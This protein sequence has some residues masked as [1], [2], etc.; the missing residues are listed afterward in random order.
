MK[1][2]LSLGVLIIFVCLF[3]VGC[4][5]SAQPTVLRVAIPYSDNVLDPETNYYINWLEKE[6]GFDIEPVIVRQ[7]VAVEYL[8]TLF[9]SSSYV[10]VVLFGDGFELSENELDEYV[11]RGE[12]AA[13]SKGEYS[14]PNYGRKTI[15]DCGQTLWINSEWL[16]NLGLSTPSTT[17]DLQEILRE[18]KYSDPNGNGL[19]DEIPLI[20]SLDSYATNPCELILNSFVHNDP[21]HNRLVKDKSGKTVN[22][23]SLDEF[24]EGTGFLHE[25]YKE[26]LLDKKTFAY[27]KKAF[28]EVVNSSADIV[29][30]FT[31]DS[32][33]DV[34]YQGNPEIMAKFIHVAPLEGPEGVKNAL[35]VSR[36]ADIGAVITAKSD[37]KEEAEKLL[38]TMLSTE[39]SLIARYGEEG[40]DWEYSDG[41]DVSIY[42]T[43]S[44][45]VTKNY[46]WNTPQNK[47][48]NGTGAM[49]VPDE[50]LKGVT[51][52]GVDSDSEYIDARAQMSYAP[53]LKDAESEEEYNEELSAY[54]DSELVRFIKGER[55][56]ENDK[57]WAQFN[58]E[59]ESG[60]N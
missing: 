21:Y 50:Y 18:F 41:I 17:E 9:A 11:K 15:G 29:G 19:N 57:D 25:L 30:A 13:N 37:K 51:W 28:T 49:Y 56:I 42:R 14:Y 31:T 4:G 48:L 23:I 12:I 58:N 38:D 46:I 36:K 10:D 53:Y 60:R 16:T 34:I 7:S 33:S 39:G 54:M 55:D 59:I 5:K 35:K 3:T 44:T 47:N 27:S 24:R 45:I 52:N 26:N 1:T 22:A 32:I 6:T 43:A 2:R 8:D 20:G 40:V